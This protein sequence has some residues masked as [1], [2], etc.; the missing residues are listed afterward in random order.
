M[1]ATGRHATHVIATAVAPKTS[2][3]TRHKSAALFYYRGC[4]FL[5]HQAAATLIVA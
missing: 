5:S 1:P 3:T 2:A 4:Q